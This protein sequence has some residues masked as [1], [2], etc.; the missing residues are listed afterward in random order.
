MMGLSRDQSARLVADCDPPTVE[1]VAS[2]LADRFDLDVEPI[3]DQ[4]RV[5]NIYNHEVIR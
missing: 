1:E 3:Q 5:L 4:L 2:E